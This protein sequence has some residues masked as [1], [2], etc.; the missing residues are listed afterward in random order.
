MSD[1]CELLLHLCHI[2]EIPGPTFDLS[3]KVFI[4]IYLSP[5]CWLLPKLIN[6]QSLY[7]FLNPPFSPVLRSDISKWSTASVFLLF[8][9]NS[10]TNAK[11]AMMRP[12]TR[13]T[14]VIPSC[15]RIRGWLCLTFGR[16]IGIGGFIASSFNFL[17]I[18]VSFNHNMVF[19]NPGC[20]G[21]M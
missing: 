13:I 4:H 17:S 15:L 2:F 6:C 21:K 16:R 7:N 10:P 14:I 20:E 1:L 19:W 9:H 11:I 12:A 5:W 8:D 18:P 3:T